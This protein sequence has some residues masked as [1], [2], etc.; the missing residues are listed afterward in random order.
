MSKNRKNY[1]HKKLSIRNYSATLTFNKIIE[2][3][4]KKEKNNTPMES[5]LRTHTAQGETS[6]VSHYRLIG[7][8]LHDPHEYKNLKI[9][10]ICQ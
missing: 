4:E 8:F 9:Q 2:R 10:R 1:L 5:H 3:K 7:W 6:Q